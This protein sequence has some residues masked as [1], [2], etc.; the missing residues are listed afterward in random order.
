MHAVCMHICRH[1]NAQAD[2]FMTLT[3]RDFSRRNRVTVTVVPSVFIARFIVS[4]RKINAHKLRFHTTKVLNFKRTS[5][6][7]DFFANEFQDF[8]NEF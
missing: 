7:F 2:I 4:N 1:V 3:V 5:Q 8:C 6:L